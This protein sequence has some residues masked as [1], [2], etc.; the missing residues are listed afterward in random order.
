[1]S[2]SPSSP[3]PLRAGGLRPAA[4]FRLPIFAN[5]EMIWKQFQKKVIY[6][7]SVS[8]VGCSSNKCDELALM[9]CCADAVH[10]KW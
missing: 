8:P 6:E 5:I 4:A 2:L 10:P 7:N 1:M 3:S 9:L